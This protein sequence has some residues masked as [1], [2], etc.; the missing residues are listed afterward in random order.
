MASKSTYPVALLILALVG[1]GVGLLIGRSRAP[2]PAPIPRD[3]APPAP[4]ADDTSAADNPYARFAIADFELTNQDGQPVTHAAFEG[5]V[6]VLTF[7]FASCPDPCPAIQRVM[8]DVQRRTSGV[9]L[10]S[11]SVDGTHDTPERIRNYALG[12][13]ADFDRWT[14][15]TGEPRKVGELVRDS[16]SFNLTDR[17]DL[18]VTRPDGTTRAQILHPTRLI[19]VGPDRK[20]IGLYPYNDAESVDRLVADANAAAG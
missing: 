9:R 2:S 17:D 10:M 8:A 7:F 1:G 15:A 13:D 5:E 11:V 3:A 14:F 19:L 20:V 16:L 4:V 6:T 18:T 12:Y